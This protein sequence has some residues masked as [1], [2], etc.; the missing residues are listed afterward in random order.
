MNP[1]PCLSLGALLAGA[2]VWCAP[3]GVAPAQTLISVS[4]RPGVLRIGERVVGVELHTVSAPVVS[5]P[6]VPQGWSIQ[7]NN[8]P[9]GSA[10]FEG[11]TQ[12]GSAALFPNELASFVVVQQ[13]DLPGL[14]FSVSGTLHASRDF[15]HDR[16]IPLGPQEIALNPLSGH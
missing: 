2:L 9:T 13:Q 8:D 1:A 11:E 15:I 16:T 4:I 5:L 10:S 14:H 3:G 12:M 6:A 7:I